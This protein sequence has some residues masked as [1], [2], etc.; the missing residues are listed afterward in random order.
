MKESS[1][2]RLCVGMFV[3]DFRKKNE[4]KTEEEKVQATLDG[5]I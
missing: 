4:N 1:H 2:K 3:S 5:C